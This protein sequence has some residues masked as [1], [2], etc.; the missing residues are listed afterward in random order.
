MKPDL[1]AVHPLPPSNLYMSKGSLGWEP[2]LDPNPGPCPHGIGGG[3]TTRSRR[4]LLGIS[5]HR[6]QNKMLPPANDNRRGTIFRFV[7]MVYYSISIVLPIGLQVVW[8]VD[9][10]AQGAARAPN[11]R[12]A[13][14]ARLRAT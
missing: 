1:S 11:P 13:R 2:R 5:I 3:I 7:G 12:S 6:E 8:Q 10:S 14:I 9:D 4:R